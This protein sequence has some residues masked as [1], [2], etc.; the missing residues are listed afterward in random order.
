MKYVED[1]FQFLKTQNCGK[2]N[3]QLNDAKNKS[4][5]SVIGF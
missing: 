3:A 5:T 1:H 4:K 2:E